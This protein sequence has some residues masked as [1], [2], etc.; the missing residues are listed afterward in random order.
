MT[1]QIPEDAVLARDMKGSHA[2][3]LD[4]KLY[5][6]LCWH[7][8]RGP[9]RLHREM[10]SGKSV[11]P[12]TRYFSA[13]SK[14]EILERDGTNC[15]YCGVETET[16]TIKKGEKVPSNGRQWDHVIPYSLGGLSVATNG[17]CACA[18]CNRKKSD[19]FY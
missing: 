16:Y 17:V 19:L 12:S 9:S 2:D 10:F 13:K 7:L 14:R 3:V 11:N 15:A 5:T 18:D 6:F 4:S 1:I 8:G